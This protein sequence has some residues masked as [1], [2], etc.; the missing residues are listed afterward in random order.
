MN[1]TPAYKQDGETSRQRR[2]RSFA[3]CT[4][5]QTVWP[6]SSVVPALYGTRRVMGKRLHRNRWVAA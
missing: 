3:L 5:Q 2:S 4:I 6:V 1:G